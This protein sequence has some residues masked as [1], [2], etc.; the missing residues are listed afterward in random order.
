MKNKTTTA[1]SSFN[2]IWQRN[3]IPSFGIGPRP[4]QSNVKN[5]IPT[6]YANTAYPTLFDQNR[7]E[8]KGHD[9]AARTIAEDRPRTDRTRA[10]SP[11]PQYYPQYSNFSNLASTM[12]RKI[13]FHRHDNPP[14]SQTP[15]PGSY[16]CNTLKMNPVGTYGSSKN[17]SSGCTKFNPSRVRSVAHLN[18][19]TMF[20]NVGPG[21]H[22][23][24][25]T[26]GCISSVGSYSNSKYRNSKASTFGKEKRMPM[27]KSYAPGPGNYIAKISDF[28]G[29]SLPD[30]A[31]NYYSNVST[32]IDSRLD[33]RST[34]SR[35]D[36]T[37]RSCT[38]LF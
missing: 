22:N 25:S 31:S 24:N 34:E 7:A 5:E 2:R 37:Y 15:G 9:F 1:F 21:T 16:R 23:V 30:V 28:E 33:N 8:L 19:T 29:K 20:N 36:S 3:K 12:H 13:D 11:G 6:A 35:L 27:P 10:L 26:F 32:R 38:P 17:R 4:D 18:G 14:R